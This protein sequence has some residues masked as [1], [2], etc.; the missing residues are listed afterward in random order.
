M[1]KAVCFQS[2]TVYREKEKSLYMP[3]VV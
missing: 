1:L 2:L 3:Q